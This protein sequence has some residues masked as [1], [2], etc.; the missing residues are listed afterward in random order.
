LI[1]EY[2]MNNKNDLLLSVVVPLYNETE[3]LTELHSQ[4]C[5]TCE[6]AGIKFEA[7]YVDD[8]STD[9]SFEVLEEIH[10][11]DNRTKV[12]QLRKNFGKSEALSAG[13]SVAE[14]KLIVTMDADLQ[15]DPSEISSLINKLNEGYDLVSGWKKYRKDPLSKK[16]PSKLFNRVTSFLTGLRIHDFNCGLKIYKKEVTESVKVYGE[17]HRYIPALAKWE[18]FCVGEIPVNHRHRKYGKTKFGFSRFTYGFLDLITVMFLSRYTKRPLHLF[19]LIGLLSSLS[20]TA[21][22]LYLII[23]R[24]TRKS[25]L[26]NRPL[27]FIGVLL[28]ILGIQF[29]SIGL[30]GEMIT[31]A[32]ASGHRYAIRRMLGV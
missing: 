27:L 25:Y 14:G 23:L 32:N 28:L 31:R 29:V 16:L 6:G 15:D 18:G 26:S 3:S 12:L 30:L 19:G 24:I 8:G 2:K 21:I 11:K 9:N 13:F 20:G 22:T 17:L 5:R 1:S 10:Q 4:I 7:I